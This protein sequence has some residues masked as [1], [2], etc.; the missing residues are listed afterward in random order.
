MKHF[1]LTI[2]FLLLNAIGA[3]C[4]H[5][6]KIPG[7][8][9]DYSNLLKKDSSNFNEYQSEYF[10]QGE[11]IIAVQH[12]LAKD[13][14]EL[15]KKN[16][17]AFDD[18][19]KASPRIRIKKEWL[20]QNSFYKTNLNADSIVLAMSFEQIIFITD[21]KYIN[22]F[23]EFLWVLEVGSGDNLNFEP[24][25][26]NMIFRIRKDKRK[27]ISYIATVKSHCEI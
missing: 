17:R 1:T 21:R 25:Y 26:M 16:P 15:F 4:Q 23:K 6:T 19:Y 20:E 13:F 2:F 8:S 18:L 22:G 7:T 14:Y 24:C 5:W 11:K 10:K 9:L 3:Y 27:K 12:W